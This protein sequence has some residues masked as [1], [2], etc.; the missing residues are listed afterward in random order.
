MNKFEYMNYIYSVQLSNKEKLVIINLLSRAD[1]NMN[2]F[3]SVKRIAEDCGISTRTVQRALKE[4][5]EG[6]F[7]KKESRFH[8]KGG[9][10][11]NYYY[12]Q[13]PKVKIDKVDLFISV[14]IE[15]SVEIKG[16]VSFFE[17]LINKVGVMLS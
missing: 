7:I 13:K 5:E 6:G 14:N 12:L 10:R 2:C 9:Q 3:P 15:K 8:K 17:R 16:K 4:L 11:S 1:K